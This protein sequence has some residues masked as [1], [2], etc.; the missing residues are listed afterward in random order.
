MGDP[1]PRRNFTFFSLF[2][3]FLLEKS[4]G[5]GPG[6]SPAPPLGDWHAWGGGAVIWEPRPLWEGA[7]HRRGGVVSIQATPPGRVTTPSSLAPPTIGP[8][9]IIFGHAHSISP[10]LTTEAPPQP[11]WPHLPALTTPTAALAPPPQQ[12]L[13]PLCLGPAHHSFGSAPTEEAPPPPQW[14]RP[15]QHWLHPLSGAI[16]TC[17]AAG[18]GMGEK[19]G[20]LWVRPCVCVSVGP[21]RARVSVRPSVTWPAGSPRGSAPRSRPSAAG[22]RR[23]GRKEPGGGVGM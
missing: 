3:T 19:P 16:G 17:G 20:G 13:H 6:E 10:A 7:E 14:P 15:P 11:L 21:S 1:S 2:S 8:T 18:R 12:R 4:G 5:E 23:G 9:S 22:C